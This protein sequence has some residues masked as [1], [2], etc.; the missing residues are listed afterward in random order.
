MKNSRKPV[1]A[2]LATLSAFM[3]RAWILIVIGILCLIGGAYAIYKLLGVMSRWLPPTPDQAHNQNYRYATTNSIGSTN[4]AVVSNS[5][6]FSTH[7][8]SVYYGV[9]GDGGW[10]SVSNMVPTDAYLGESTL[11]DEQYRYAVAVFYGGMTVVKDC[12]FDVDGTLLFNKTTVIQPN[13]VAIERS[14]NMLN[15]ESVYSD[16]KCPT[17]G[18]SL[19]TDK[20]ATSQQAF[21]RVRV[22]KFGE[23][24]DQ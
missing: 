9:D 12:A 3:A 11:V 5:K 13:L 10:V 20:N 18:V 17:F 22:D 19:F 14:T 24:E 4:T 6:D 1:V 8:F 21:Y 23:V 7:T 2:I 16:D 15:W